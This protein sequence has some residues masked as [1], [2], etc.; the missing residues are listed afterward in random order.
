[1]H[2]D[3]EQGFPGEVFRYRGQPERPAFSGLFWYC[4]A[5]LLELDS[6]CAPTRCLIPFSPITSQMQCLMPKKADLTSILTGF[7]SQNVS[8]NGELR[9]AQCFIT[10][11][12]LALVV[13]LCVWGAFKVYFC[14]SFSLSAYLSVCLGV[15][16]GFHSRVCLSVC[17]PVSASICAVCPGF[18][19]GFHLRVCLSVC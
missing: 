12:L 11:V 1:M 16:L 17:L 9:L 5:C 8:R 13:C 4:L 6:S 7:V 10:V 3:D 2:G 15:R 14:L 19:L 18:R